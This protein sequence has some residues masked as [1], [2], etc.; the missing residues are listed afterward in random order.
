MK[1]LFYS[2]TVF[3]MLVGIWLFISPFVFGYA[4]THLLQTTCSLEPLWSSSQSE[5]SS[6]RYTTRR[7]SKGNRRGNGT[8]QREGVS[9]SFHEPAGTDSP[10][11]IRLKTFELGLEGFFYS[12]P[13]RPPAVKRCR[14]PN[15]HA[16]SCSDQFIEYNQPSPTYKPLLLSTAALRASGLYPLMMVP[17]TSIKGTPV[18]PPLL[19]SISSFL[20]LSR[21]IL[22][23]IK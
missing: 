17:S 9:H 16:L 19:L 21:S 3:Q 22:Y 4:E 5:R 8:C 20:S 11:L 15:T 2:W 6:T 23:S 13:P 10:G 14:R 1:S 12:N 7:G 18:E